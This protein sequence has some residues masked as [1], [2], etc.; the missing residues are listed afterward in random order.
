MT[1]Q[2]NVW[3]GAAIL[4][5]GHPYIESATA[6]SICCGV[7]VGSILVSD[8]ACTVLHVYHNINDTHHN[9]TWHCIKYC[10]NTS[11]N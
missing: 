5:A 8:G 2:C 11:S 1:L 3:A 10:I 9:F 4:F 6:L 7:H